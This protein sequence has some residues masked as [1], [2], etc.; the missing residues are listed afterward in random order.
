M[1][2]VADKLGLYLS[3]LFILICFSYIFKPN[4]AFTYAEHLYVGFGA[5]QAIIA[6][7]NN[8]KQ[9]AVQSL[10]EGDYSVLVPI[11]LGLMLFARYKK[12]WSFVART[13]MAFMMG[14]AAGVTITGVIDAQFIKQIQATMLPLTSINNV[15]L[16]VGTAATVAFFLFI[17][18]SKN[19]QGYNS[20]PGVGAIVSNLGRA[21]IMVALGSSYGFTVMAR[22]S[23][24]IA[25]LQFLL[26]SWVN[27]LPQ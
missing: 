8:V 26:G 18:L 22:L 3:G 17:P 4:K 10:Y 15:V 21:T 24:L 25:R 23:Y 27:L 5:A 19:T 14:V 9:S 12:R 16:V 7:Y 11:L 20:L 13:P 6:G 2:A 1:E